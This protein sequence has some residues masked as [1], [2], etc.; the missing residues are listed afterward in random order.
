MSQGRGQKAAPPGLPGVQGEGGRAALHEGHDQEGFGGV[1]YLLAA[2]CLSLIL[3]GTILHY[4]ALLRYILQDQLGLLT[5]SLITMLNRYDYLRYIHF[6]DCWFIFFL[7]ILENIYSI[8]EGS[9]C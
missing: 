2:K 9:T 3:C 7:I 4:I 5:F 6:S 1:F 8:K